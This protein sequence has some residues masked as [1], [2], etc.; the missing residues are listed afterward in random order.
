MPSIDDAA[1]AAGAACRPLAM[2]PMN[3]NCDPPVNM[4]RDSAMA[5]HVSSPAA[6]ARAPKAMP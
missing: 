4:S 1:I 3:A 2:M 6:T 5:C